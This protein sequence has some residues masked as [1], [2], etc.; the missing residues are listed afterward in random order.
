MYDSQTIAINQSDKKKINVPRKPINLEETKYSILV[1][2]RFSF[3]LTLD[4]N[5]QSGEEIRG[6]LM[7]DYSIPDV[8]IG[9]M[10]LDE[11]PAAELIR[12]TRAF[13][14]RITN[15]DRQRLAFELRESGHYRAIHTSAPPELQQFFVG[16][17]DLD[18]ELSRRY[19]N[20]AL[21]SHARF[22]PSP[23]DP[24]RRQSSAIF[25]SQDDSV[26]MTIDAFPGA[27]D[28]ARLEFTFTL[29][30]T[31]ALR[32]PLYPVL[33]TEV[34]QWLKLMRR[35]SGINFLWTFNRWEQ[36]YFIFV[37]R[38]HFA[39][40]CAFSPHGYEAS[41]RLTP[42]MVA[43]L[44]NWL[45]ATW[46]PALDEDFGVTPSRPY[47]AL[48]ADDGPYEDERPDGP[49]S[50]GWDEVLASPPPEIDLSQRNLSW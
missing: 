16:E 26:S 18:E 41:V 43:L 49:A 31:L 40:F 23:G 20:A 47:D 19:V 46:L 1:I 2:M 14:R 17:I 8:L 3:Y 21:L 39:R 35:D 33:A 28:S 44:C 50:N 48:E 22:T 15:Q 29:F 38:E 45:E 34:S 11:L 30:S 42:D 36:P 25:S 27:D 5:K 24:P 4:Y 32:F 13:T 10:A 37:V 7:S 9:P 6:A 12:I